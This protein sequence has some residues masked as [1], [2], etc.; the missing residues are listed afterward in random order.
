MK[1]LS[2]MPKKSMPF[3]KRPATSIASP[4]KNPMMKG[5]K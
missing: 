4:A 2:S 5:G 3:S 1:K